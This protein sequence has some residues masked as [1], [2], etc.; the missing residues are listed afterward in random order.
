MRLTTL[1]LVFGAQRREH[2]IV[3][4]Q[5]LVLNAD[6]WNDRVA[7]VQGARCPE[8]GSD[9]AHIFSEQK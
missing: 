6:S 9:D 1:G 2:D 5:M 7:W 4:V 3:S 8:L